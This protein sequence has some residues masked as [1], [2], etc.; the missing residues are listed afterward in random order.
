MRFV[1]FILFTF[2]FIT[3]PLY[4]MKIQLIVNTP[5]NTP[6]QKIYITGSSKQLTEWKLPGREL[7]KIG[8]RSFT[9]TLEAQSDLEFKI[10]RDSWENQAADKEG[11][12]LENLSLSTESN[13]AVV[14]IVNWQ[15]LGPLKKSAQLRYHPK[16]HADQLNNDRNLVVYLP[17]SYLSDSQ[18]RYPVIYMQDGENC[19]DPKTSSYGVDWSADKIASRLI[20]EKKI[21]EVIIVAIPSIN[22]YEEYSPYRLGKKYDHFVTK[23]II[24]FIDSHYRT[25]TD[26]NNRYLI[27][28]SM[29]AL[30]SFS[31]LWWHPDLFAAAAGVS[32][33]AFIHERAIFKLLKQRVP[34]APFY[35]YMDH[36]GFGIDSKYAPSAEEFYQKL[37]KK[38]RVDQKVDYETFPYADHSETHWAARLDLVLQKLLHR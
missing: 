28:S 16:F 4:A 9:I 2:L 10:T 31:Q 21:P 18:K 34:T 5:F 29:G 22:R 32:L 20:A 12:S 14:T 6:N 8:H 15:D 19:F 11:N 26:R 7:K 13:Q 3:S 38:L 35:F 23:Q 25:L 30:I 36:G 17:P 1:K 27:G 33:P 24:P 37:S